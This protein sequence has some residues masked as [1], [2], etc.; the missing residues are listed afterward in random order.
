ME[1][2]A[3]QGERLT[4]VTR[5]LTTS[6]IRTALPLA[7]AACTGAAS[8]PD[9]PAGG[10]V[11]PV[12]T[13]KLEQLVR[14]FAGGVGIYVRHLPTGATAE[15][16][17]DETFPTAS[18]IKIPLLV[19]LYDQVE[20]GL[21]D[22]ATA[23][24]F[25]DTLHYRYAER[26]DVVAYMAPGDTLPLSE[27]TFLMLSVSDNLASLWI[28]ALVGGGETVNAWLAAHG[29]PETRVNSRTPG[30][31][32]DRQEFGWGQTT[33]REMAELMVS[34]RQGRAVSP[35]ASEEMYRMLTSSYWRGV[36]VSQIP[37][38]VQVASKQGFVDESRSEVLLVNAP[39]GDYVLAVI[40]KNQI[41][42]SLRTDNPG[43]RLIRA[44][45]RTVYTHFN[46]DDPW[47]PIPPATDVPARADAPT[48]AALALDPE[49][50]RIFVVP[51]GAA[52]PIPFGTASDTAAA[53]VSR[54]LG[55]VPIE[56]GQTPDCG[57]GYIRWPAG[58]TMTL[59]DGR[60]VGWSIG[61]ADARLT[62]PAGIGA[63]SARS[64]LESAHAAKIFPSTLGTEFSVG[65]I[66]GVLDSAA[67]DARITAMWAG[68][69]CLAR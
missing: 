15:L 64:E 62:T 34:I 20:R 61:G 23:Y 66:A 42:T 46:P 8:A 48:G 49:G 19:T 10:A 56:Q 36:A 4:R 53:R 3:L 55:A 28:Q 68:E 33:P 29:Y 35:A 37:P 1:R 25:P 54:T 44:I 12:L 17:A 5:T 63:G 31:E 69:A 59:R 2:H 9:H 38:H 47:Q 40:T 26:T 27:L 24:A 22:P 6:F 18:L 58:L 57:L 45:S 16:R 52:R 67:P 51:S 14:S 43:Y 41:D 39:T 60:F 7:L 50:L 30:R 13:T 11:D 32:M 65:G 21:L